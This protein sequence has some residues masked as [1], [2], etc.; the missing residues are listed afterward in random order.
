MKKTIYILLSLINIFLL[1]SCI[2]LE[3]EI[4]ISTTYKGNEIVV[5]GY[6][7]ND[8]ALASIQQT[9]PSDDS[10]S[11][12]IIIKGANVGLYS[13]QENKLIQ[14]LHTTDSIMYFTPEQ[15]KPKENTPYFIKVSAPGFETVT[16]A[17]QKV[18]N[19]L[20]FDTVKV[21]ITDNK[22][23]KND[24]AYEELFGKNR[25][26]DVE[27]SFHTTTPYASV[28]VLE[29]GYYNNE[30]YED[31][32]YYWKKKYVKKLYEIELSYYGTLNPISK[33]FNFDNNNDHIETKDSIT[34]NDLKYP[35]FDR[36]DGIY[37]RGYYLSE[38]LSTFITETTMYMEN[39]TSP[40]SAL[41]GIIESNMSNNIGYFG[42][43][44]AKDTLITLPPHPD[45]VN[46][47]YQHN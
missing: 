24:D 17:P 14:K 16:S 12:P 41:A 19:A 30:Y 34:Y 20:K 38:D 29:L 4:T 21:S 7:S 43:M 22:H 2:E 28:N 47:F 5:V 27:Y 42:T 23:W 46:N 45:D 37:L 31:Y 9:M 44:T 8:G 26:I 1:S 11:E 15:F 25:N 3:K 36:I 18:S 10:N 13:A 32:N 6:L 40:F 35:V 39:R 33:R